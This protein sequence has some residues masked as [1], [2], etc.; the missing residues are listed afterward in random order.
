MATT[1]PYA[2]AVQAAEAAGQIVFRV[3]AGTV[4]D[5]VP[6]LV[7]QVHGCAGF[8]LSVSFGKPGEPEP[9]V[10]IGDVT[11]KQQALETWTEAEAVD[12]IAAVVNAGVS[13]V[14]GRFSFLTVAIRIALTAAINGADISPEL[15]ATL[16][17][18]IERVL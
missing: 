2:T 18:V 1:F 6:L 9:I 16:L 3:R 4:K 12:Y 14:T 10:P 5:D 8:I 13:P 11:A 17:A 7:N 15:K